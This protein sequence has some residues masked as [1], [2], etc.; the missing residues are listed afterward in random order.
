MPI[1]AGRFK[2]RFDFTWDFSFYNFLAVRNIEV[3]KESVEDFIKDIVM[4]Q[5]VVYEKCDISD[6]SSVRDFAKNVQ[7]KYPKINLLINNGKKSRPKI[8]PKRLMN[9]F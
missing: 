9:S 6:M 3:A 7:E 2:S 1:C 4:L 8:S 5:K